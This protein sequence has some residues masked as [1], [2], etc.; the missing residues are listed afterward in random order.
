MVSCLSGKDPC[1]IIKHIIILIHC[2]LFPAFLMS[3][4]GFSTMFIV[5]Q[6]GFLAFAQIAH[7]CLNGHTV[8]KPFYSSVMSH[9]GRNKNNRFF[10]FCMGK[11]CVCVC[12]RVS[13]CLCG[14]NT[15]HAALNCCC[16][17]NGQAF[18]LL[19][20]ADYKMF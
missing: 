15:T 19:R 11:K 14:E 12:A 20:D 8:T 5:F 7:P 1:K 17:I 9:V 3:I 2:K 13:V 16:V 18:F 6:M 4:N 10:V